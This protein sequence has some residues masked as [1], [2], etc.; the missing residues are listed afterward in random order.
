MRKAWVDWLESLVPEK[1][2]ELLTRRLAGW[3]V[4]QGGEKK[5]AAAFKDSLSL[6]GL[7]VLLF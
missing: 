4:V 2:G 5:N 3:C 7:F 1:S 6:Q